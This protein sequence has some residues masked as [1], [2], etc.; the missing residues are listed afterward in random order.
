MTSAC[1]YC[2]KQFVIQFDF[3]AVSTTYPI[4]LDF[5]LYS[6]DGF[7]DRQLCFCNGCLSGQHLFADNIGEFSGFVI[8]GYF[9]FATGG[10][11]GAGPRLVLQCPEPRAFV[12]VA[13]FHSHTPVLARLNGMEIRDIVGTALGFGN[14]MVDVPAVSR[15]LT[16]CSI[17][18]D[19]P[20]NIAA[21]FLGVATADRGGFVPYSVFASWSAIRGFVVGGHTGVFGWGSVFILFMIEM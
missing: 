17:M 6:V 18:Y 1:R 21:P 3:L 14:V 9:G 7:N 4:H 10:G 20:V 11:P 15:R 5:F 8:Q 16:V 12:F 13:H 2:F 19:I